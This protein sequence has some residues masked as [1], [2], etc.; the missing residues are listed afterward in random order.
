MGTGSRWGRG[1]RQGRRVARRPVCEVMER[2]Q[3]LSSL[4]VTSTKDD[5][6]PN[7]LRWAIEQAN[8]SA[9]AAPV[10][11]DF[12]IQGASGLAIHLASPLPEIHVPV[13]IDG[14]TQPD[15]KS[16]RLNS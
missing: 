9:S 3:L 2:R 16:T 4:V 6:S 8:A 1:L 7:T 14:T 5:A 12:D 10:A 11:I 13:L 15:R